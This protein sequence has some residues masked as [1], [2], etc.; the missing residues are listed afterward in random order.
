MQRAL[1]REHTLGSW[2]YLQEIG[3][4][5]FKN[6]LVRIEKLRNACQCHGSI[7]LGQSWTLILL[8][9]QDFGCHNYDIQLLKRTKIAT[10]VKMEKLQEIGTFS[11]SL[12]RTSDLHHSWFKELRVFECQSE[13]LDRLVENVPISCHFSILN[14]A[15]LVQA[16]SETCTTK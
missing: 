10:F 8:Y 12:S 9:W 3:C 15:I 16:R 14:V 1:E 13:V 6:N 5:Y 7:V 4:L 2:K 11:K